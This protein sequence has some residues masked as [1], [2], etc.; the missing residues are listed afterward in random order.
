VNPL[1][2]KFLVGLIRRL[3]QSSG[4]LLTVSDD[5]L[6]EVIVAFATI[7]GFAWGFWND[8][9]EQQKLNTAASLPRT[10]VAQVELAIKDG[11]AVSART[12][13]TEIPHV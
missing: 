6:T 1:Y 10:T 12:P 4:L 5:T 8:Y 11:D 2:V 7:L 13:K 9:K 3:L